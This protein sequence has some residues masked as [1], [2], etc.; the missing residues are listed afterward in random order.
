MIVRILRGKT[1]QL[2]EDPAERDLEFYQLIH[3]SF[4]TDNYSSIYIVGE[5][6]DKE[7]AVRSVP[8]LCKNRRHVFYGNNLFVKRGLLW[9]QGK[10]RGEKSEKLPVQR[11]G[12]YKEQYR[13]GDGCAG[14]PGIL[15]YY[16]GRE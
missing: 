12:T 15:S 3:E 1:I 8:L 10:G 7:W 16:R 9:R 6:F 14:F 5:G 4:G 11:A 13:H 2:S